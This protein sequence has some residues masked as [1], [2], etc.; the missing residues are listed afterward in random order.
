MCIAN[1]F[2]TANAGEDQVIA[3]PQTWATLDGKQS[4]DDIKI[5]GWKWEQIRY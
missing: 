5:V 3:L 2:F 1:F 4:S